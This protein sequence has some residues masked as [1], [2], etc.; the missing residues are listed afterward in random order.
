MSDDPFSDAARSDDADARALARRLRDDPAATRRLDELRRAAFGRDGSTA[1]LV[2]V[3]APLR[4]RT[5]V[6]AVELP[7]PLVALLAEEARLTDEGAG[8]L[9]AD[10]PGP[11]STPSTGSTADG[12]ADPAA[13]EPTDD[14]SSETRE[15]ADTREDPSAPHPRRPRPAPLAA[16]AAGLL[17]LAGLGSAAASGAFDVTN[18]DGS[19]AEAGRSSTAP[20]DADADAPT[21]PPRGQAMGTPDGRRGSAVPDFSADP[22]VPL[23][24]GGEEDASARAD[25]EWAAVLARDPDAV[26][27]DVRPELTVPA[28]RWLEQHAA[29][30]RASGVDVG[31]VDPEADAR[32][33]A[34]EVDPVLAY[35]C[36]VRFPAAE[37]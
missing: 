26:R 12:G 33:S 37:P 11:V 13:A 19:A 34:S 8:L 25:A 18:P 20:R 10:A 27:P 32:L 7:V 28:D 1:P 16:V 31:V 17:L 22:P 14:R 36:S 35:A 21:T 4:A 2:E 15:D 6:D 29:C 9:A 24:S 3:P 5:G 23:P 30:L